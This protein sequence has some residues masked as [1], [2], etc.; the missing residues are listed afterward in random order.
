M[1]TKKIFQNN[2]IRKQIN[3]ASYIPAKHRMSPEGTIVP[4][5]LR[6]NRAA[7]LNVS[8]RNALF[9]LSLQQFKVIWCVKSDF[10]VWWRNQSKKIRR[11]H[12]KILNSK[13]QKTRQKNPFSILFK[14]YFFDSPMSN[15]IKICVLKFFMFIG[16]NP[17][18]INED[19]EVK[20]NQ[21]QVQNRFWICLVEKMVLAFYMSVPNR[22][23]PEN[24]TKFISIWILV[25]SVKDY[26][27]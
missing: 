17:S 23:Y 5:E 16:N 9:R 13:N 27:Y 12:Q 24:F 7:F 8:D 19:W 25:W 18:Y 3:S 1:C 4:G 15:R 14:E 21:H 10:K 2:T 20:H 6:R 11:N 22:S 26:P